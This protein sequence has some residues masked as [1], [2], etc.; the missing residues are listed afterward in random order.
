MKKLL[1]FVIIVIFISC[2]D[3]FDKKIERDTVEIV[4]PYNGATLKSGEIFFSWKALDGASRY[5]LVIVTPSFDDALQVAADETIAIVDSAN[6]STYNYSVNLS[7]G[8]YQWY[9]QAQNFSYSSKKQIYDL[10][11]VD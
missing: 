8:K 4:A 9:V 7:E 1:L 10:T 5:Q 6:M 2:D 3:V 11:V